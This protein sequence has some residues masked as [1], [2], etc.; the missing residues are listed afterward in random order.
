MNFFD[1]LLVYI[2]ILNR[3]VNLSFSSFNTTIQMPNK[4]NFFHS[5]ADS[6]RASELF[7]PLNH[8]DPVKQPLRKL[9]TSPGSVYRFFMPKAKRFTDP[10]YLDKSH[11]KHKFNE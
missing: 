4:T 5:E 6:F 11:I 9:I 10:S 8:S 7:R 3:R 1:D 2:I